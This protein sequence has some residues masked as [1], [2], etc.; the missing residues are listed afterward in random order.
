MP[1]LSGSREVLYRFNNCTSVVIG[2]ARMYRQTQH[3]GGE[4]GGSR[5]RRSELSQRPR[6]VE[7]RG[8]VNTTA[9]I[10]CSKVLPQRV[11][12]IGLNGVLVKD[13]SAPRL[14]NLHAVS[15]LRAVALRIGAAG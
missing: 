14:G 6:L 5:C 7:Q 4:C 15:Q 8:L 11:A 9:D 13:M 12:R 3:A 2:K 10:A 1:G